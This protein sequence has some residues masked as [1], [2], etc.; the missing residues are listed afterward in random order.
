MDRGRTELEAAFVLHRRPY[1]ETSMIVDFL[2]LNHGRLAAVAK[3]ASRSGSRWQAEL[4]P[5]HPVRISWTGRG[6]LKTLIGSE[7]TAPAVALAGNR[8]FCGFYLNEVLQRLLSEA[9]PA[10]DL[11]STYLDALEQLA[12]PQVPM[13]PVLRRFEQYLAREL[14]F[15]I[16]WIQTTDTGAP[17]QLGTRYGFD[18]GRGVLEQSQGTLNGIPGRLLLALDEGRLDDPEVLKIAKKLMRCQ[19]D[20]LLQGRPLNSRRLFWK[21]GAQQ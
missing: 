1:R 9:E 20:H 16:S 13:E 17:V 15:G 10:P 6:S 21:Q 7:A 4:Q 5:F 14:G 12:D 3:G 18:P 8:L 11:F 19:M 2:T